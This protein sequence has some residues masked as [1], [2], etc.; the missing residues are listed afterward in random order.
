MFYLNMSVK[1]GEFEALKDDDLKTHLN[2]QDKVHS[3]S[4][5]HVNLKLWNL[6]I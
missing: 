6:M 3:L 2:T 1:T 5:K 4:V